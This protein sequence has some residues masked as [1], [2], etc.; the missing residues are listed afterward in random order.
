[1]RETGNGNT[2]LDALELMVQEI[3]T[4]RR[5]MSP[6]VRM[7][8]VVR[9][10]DGNLDEIADSIRLTARIQCAMQEDALTLFAKI[11][12]AVTRTA[13]ELKVSASIDVFRAMHQFLPNVTAMAIV[14]KN[15]ELLGPTKYTEE[16]QKYTKEMQ[17]T[18]GIP[19]EGIVDK[20]ANFTDA[21]NRPSLYGYASDIGDASWIA[22]EVYFVVRTLPGVPMHQWQGTAFSAH[23]IA[24]KG[25]LKASKILS[26]TI[27]DYLES[28]SLQ[29]SIL[30]DFKRNKKSYNYK[31]LLTTAPSTRN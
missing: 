21:S 4:L 10:D 12:Q 17:G 27:I 8:Y 3:K 14:Q 29:E 24:H 23:S 19:T 30:K 16:E 18:L 7:N 15:M 1:M 2:T 9:Q 6:L 25:M 22:P 11:Q 20:I 31:S 13:T 28:K 26:M 5:Q